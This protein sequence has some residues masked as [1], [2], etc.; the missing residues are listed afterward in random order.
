MSDTYTPQEMMSVVLDPNDSRFRFRPLFVELFFPG[1]ATFRTRKIMLDELDVENVVMSPFCSPMVGS[2]VMR[3]RGYESRDFM[4]GY[5]KPKHS[6]DPTKTVVRLPGESPENLLDPSYRRTRLISN[7]LKRQIDAIKARTE[8]LAVKAITTGKNVIEGDGVERYEIDWGIGEMNII[9]QAGPTAWSAQDAATFDPVEDI[10]TY[11]SAANGPVNVMIMG[12]EVWRRL[13]SFARF[14][15]YF[16]ILRGSDSRAELAIKGLGDIVSFKGYLGDMA[17]MVYSGKYQDDTGAEHFYLDQ[18]VF[19]LGN[20]SNKGVVAYGAIQEQNAIREGVTEAQ[21]Y[22]R[23]WIQDGDPAIEF[24]QTHSA[25]QPVPVN[26][27]R[28]VTVITA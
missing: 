24:V 3:D 18:D 27:N 1:V 6:I 15:E 20:T 19:V 12:G 2:Q 13:R 16:E 14:R 7:A 21:Y 23:N 5:M 25:P 11:A 8:W 28:F 10:E 4:P 9:S 17:L 22:P 26:I